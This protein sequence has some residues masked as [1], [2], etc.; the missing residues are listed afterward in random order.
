MYGK[1]LNISV[2][3]KQ[4]KIMKY[5]NDSLDESVI[6]FAKSLASQ[7]IDVF[8]P[9]DD[10]FNDLCHKFLNADGKDIILKDRR[11]DYFIN[12]SLCQKGCSYIDVNYELNVA[13]C[14]C[15]IS[16]VQEESIIENNEEKNLKM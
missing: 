4:I 13:N 1:N 5:I 8:N 3:P 2:C 15:D 7:G 6:E 10:F 14:L 16:S 9:N 12:I 11:N